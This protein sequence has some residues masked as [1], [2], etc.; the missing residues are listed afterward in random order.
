MSIFTMYSLASQRTLERTTPG[1]AASGDGKQMPTVENALEK[2]TAFIPSEAI[3]LYVSGLG[4]FAPQ[5]PHA[6]WNIFW[7]CLA[8]IPVF[9]FLSYLQNRKHGRPIPS[10]T[11]VL[12]LL[13][14]AAVAFGVWAAAMPQ[15]PFISLWKNAPQIAGFIV[16]PLAYVMSIIAD[17]C[18]AVPK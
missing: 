1:M 10:I 7:I 11:I 15:T 3:A 12:L 5:S 2:I 9:M 6:K 13:F 8:F 14:F 16:I 17:L 4:I 18:D